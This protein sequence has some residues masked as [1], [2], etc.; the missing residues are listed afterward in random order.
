MTASS[1]QKPYS[2]RI[3]PEQERQLE[4]SA[5]ESEVKIA[6]LKLGV[7]R[8]QILELVDKYDLELIEQQ[9]IWLPLRR[10]RKP[11][12][13]IVS[14]IKEN[15]EEPAAALEQTA[16]SSN[17]SVNKGPAPKEAGDK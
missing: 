12:S 2:G 3:T 11:S 15:Y 9:L 6:L 10:P 13:L 14:A 17:S 7:S 5:R 8:V 16:A 1:E 4:R